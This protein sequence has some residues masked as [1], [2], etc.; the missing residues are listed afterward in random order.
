MKNKILFILSFV[1]LSIFTLAPKVFAQNSS[2]SSAVLADARGIPSSDIR[3]KILKEFLESYNSPLAPLALVFVET[4][5]TYNLDWRLLAAISGVESTFGQQIPSGSYNGW[6]WGVY[7]NNATYFSSWKDGIQIISRGLRE[8]YMDKWGATNVYEIGRMYAASSAW[9]SHVEYF[10]NRISDFT[11]LN[12]R[13]SL[14]I[15]L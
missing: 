1:I 12:P 11:L 8:N 10:M 14:S 5:D 13:D 3:V 4:A 6:G 7:G 2:R 9:A 15:S